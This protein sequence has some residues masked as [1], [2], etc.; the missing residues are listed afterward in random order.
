MA[1]DVIYSANY[2]KDADIWAMGTIWYEMF[3]L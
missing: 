3:T 1:Q 2:T